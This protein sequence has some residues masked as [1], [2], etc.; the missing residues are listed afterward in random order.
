MIAAALLA[1]FGGLTFVE[2]ELPVVVPPESIATGNFF[3]TA[4][5]DGDG[6]PDL[7]LPDRILLQRNGR[8]N[9]DSPIPVPDHSRSTYDLWKGEFYFFGSGHLEIMRWTDK[10]WERRLEQDMESPS[11]ASSANRA[12][13]AGRR[14]FFMPFLHDLNGDGVPEIAFPEESGITIFARNGKTYRRVSTLKIFPGLHYGSIPR[15]RLWPP[16][17]RRIAFPPRQMSCRCVV[18]GTRL[19]LI[20]PEEL[21]GKQVRY[22]VTRY[23]VDPQHQYAVIPDKT[24]QI[25]TEP[26]NR[27]M[28]PL[29][30]RP[31]DVD[32]A[33][34]D[35]EYAETSVLP[36]PIFVTQVTTDNGAHVESFRAPFF[37][38]SRG[39]FVDMNGDDRLDIVAEASDLFKGGV[40]ESIERFTNGTS[41][42]HEL[43]V[44]IQDDQGRFPPVPSWTASFHIEM[45]H[46]PI[47][48]DKR[49]RWYQSG[50]LLDASGDFNKDGYRDVVAHDLPNRLAIYLNTGSGLSSRPDITI[51]FDPDHR[52]D[53]L[54]LDGDGRSDIVVQWRDSSQSPPV[55]R[56]RAYLTRE[57]AP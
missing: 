51:P 43:R 29:A 33:G 20:A 37:R 53:A 42:Q 14:I 6:V 7:I 41:V 52:F 24:S 44:Y 48:N 50:V 19:T 16:E 15:Q 46:P 22:R 9:I 47:Q 32:F 2:Q 31:G 30:L 8:F 55:E 49:F 45:T 4:D 27:Y 54:D 12:T 36:Q 1:M 21:P 13:P 39:S 10:G 23:E 5:V 57:A 28:Q 38:S 56:C 3:H 25:I 40:R 18:D 26:M 17:A 35:W 11:A 34:G